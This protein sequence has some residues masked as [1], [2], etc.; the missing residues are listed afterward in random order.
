MKVLK[1]AAAIFVAFAVLFGG[2]IA[3]SPT[4]RATVSGVIRSWFYDRTEYRSAVQVEEKE[5]VIGYIPE[6][7]EK[8][9]EFEPTGL[10]IYENNDGVLIYIIIWDGKIEI[11]NE[12]SVFYE[13]EINGWT[14]DIYESNDPEYPNIIMLYGDAGVIISINS[15]IELDEII[16]IAASIE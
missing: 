6:G 13:T 15:M 1:S 8:V 7:F 14:A 5:W 12:H 11:D 3:V 10:R 9:E 16:K 2:T 4:V